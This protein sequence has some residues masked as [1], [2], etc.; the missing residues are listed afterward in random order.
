MKAHQISFR[1]YYLT[2]AQERQV[3]AHRLVTAGQTVFRWRYRF[4]LHQLL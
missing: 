4:I 1:L 2:G 3:Q